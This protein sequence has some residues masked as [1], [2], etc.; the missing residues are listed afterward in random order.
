MRE[1]N[2]KKEYEVALRGTNMSKVIQARTVA[3]AKAM[4]YRVL[5]ARYPSKMVNVNPDR[6][7]VARLL[8]VYKDDK[9]VGHYKK[10]KNVFVGRRG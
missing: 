10:A 8:R 6:D 5:K 2:V 3:E 9:M 4:Y 7:L 1:V